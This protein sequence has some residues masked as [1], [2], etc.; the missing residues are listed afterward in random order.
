M[1]DYEGTLLQKVL[2]VPV[3]AVWIIL[4]LWALMVGGLVWLAI[5]I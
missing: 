5:T 1:K 2:T 4:I 3:S